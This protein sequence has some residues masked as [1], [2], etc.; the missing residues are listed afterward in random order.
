MKVK[1]V[2]KRNPRTGRMGYSTCTVGH[3]KVTWNELVSEA[4]ENTTFSRGEGE[5]ICIMMMDTLCDYLTAGY[6]VELRGLGTFRLQA[7]T[8]WT[9]T[10]QEQH[11][12]DV[13]ASVRF[14]PCRE[15]RQYMEHPRV[16]WTGRL[17]FPVDNEDNV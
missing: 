2:A 17:V 10:P 12:D 15:L 14:E 13:R 9:A 3:Q 4:L 11:K 6:P 7:R 1:R 8:P 5:G 16:E